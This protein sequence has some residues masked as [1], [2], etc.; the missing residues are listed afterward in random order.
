MNKA[1]AKTIQAQPDQSKPAPTLT[2]EKLFAAEQRRDLASHAGAVALGTEVAETI[3]AE[4]SVERML[5]DQM[6]VAHK[7]AMRF[8]A[9]AQ[10][11]LSRYSNTGFKYPNAS[12]E[13]ARMATIAAR[14][15]D[16]YQR[17]LLTIDRIRNG[18][19]Q[20]VTVQHVNVTEGGQ[21]VVAGTVQNQGK[22][23]RRGPSDD[24]QGTG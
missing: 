7:I 3:S 13:A 18:G 22:R 4:N 12:V 14:L 10:E 16:T 2:D 19:Q 15:M 23:K 21:A 20:T 5:A 6:A 9:D 1:L 17:M 8:A 11:E 24:D